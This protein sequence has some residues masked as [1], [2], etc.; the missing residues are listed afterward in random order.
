MFRAKILL[1]LSLFCLLAGDVQ[2]AKQYLF[3]KSNT[4]T[5]SK[6]L[7]V[8]A[9]PVYVMIN[10][11][12]HTGIYIK[13]APTLET[14]KKMGLKE[15]MVLL[16]M[17]GYSIGS[18][19]AADD[20]VMQR[21]NGGT[22]QF[23]YVV[24]D[25]GVPTIR[26]AQGEV[27]KTAAAATSTG[28]SSSSRGESISELEQISFSLV[29]QSREAEGLSSV[30]SDSSLS[31]LA[32]KYAEYMAAHPEPYDVLKSSRSPHDDLQGRTAADRAHEAGISYW[33]S[34]NIGRGTLNGFGRS[35]SFTIR[36]V[37]QQ[38]MAEP[39]GMNNHRGNIVNP[40]AK[41]LGVGVA[42]SGDRL[43]MAQEFGTN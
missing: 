34:E 3:L 27:V 19:A 6:Q 35:G 12:R 8:V 33:Q 42:I 14:G 11:A 22:M 17:G 18:S 43:Y 38:M 7:G 16:T 1:A 21:S 28:V 39:P 41:R 2:A 25:H 37:H 32:R 26:S 5:Y 10:N 23:T 13:T 24:V 40:Q 36:A 9:V 29:N 4:P 20:C 31:N 15:G 30:Q